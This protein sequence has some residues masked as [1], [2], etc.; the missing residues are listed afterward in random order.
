[1]KFYPICQQEQNMKHIIT[2]GLVILLLGITTAKAEWYS[3][4]TLH[5]GD[6]GDWV[7]AAPSNHLATSA[8]F[9]ATTS[10]NG[11]FTSQISRTIS[12]TNDL[13]PYSIK[14][15]VCIDAAYGP[16]LE[17]MKVSEIAAACMALMGWLK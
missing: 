10:M 1:M 5:R 16:S 14:L 17:F 9:V 12:T 8:D 4:G 2:F 6:M 13:L 11:S 7:D 3:G 15:R